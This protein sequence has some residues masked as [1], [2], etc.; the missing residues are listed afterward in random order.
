MPIVGLAIEEPE[1][2][3]AAS[4]SPASRRSDSATIA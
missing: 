3:E 1:R 2:L 4:L